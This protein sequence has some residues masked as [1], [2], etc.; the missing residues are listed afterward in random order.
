MHN[1]G[2]SACHNREMII[3]I[4]TILS[5]IMV[6][7]EPIILNS[8]ISRRLSGTNVSANVLFTQGISVW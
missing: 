2:I 6:T 8:L 3:M 4:D 1:L 7:K 5:N